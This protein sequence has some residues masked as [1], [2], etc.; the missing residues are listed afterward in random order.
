MPMVVDRSVQGAKWNSCAVNHL[1]CLFQIWFRK[2][3]RV[4]TVNTD[5]EIL[6]R[7]FVWIWMLRNRNVGIYPEFKVDSYSQ[8]NQSLPPSGSIPPLFPREPCARGHR[9]PEEPREELH[10]RPV[11]QPRDSP[12]QSM[13]VARHS[14]CAPRHVVTWGFPSEPW[15]N[16]NV[17]HRLTPKGFEH[18]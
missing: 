1:G 7:D 4:F 2:N 9:G 3:N 11:A 8:Y 15:T 10:W 6:R 17:Q 18:K 16:V 14:P 5:D 12:L 13:W